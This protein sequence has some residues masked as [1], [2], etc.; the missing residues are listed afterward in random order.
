MTNKITPRHRVQLINQSTGWKSD[1]DYIVLV[2]LD[3]WLERQ[4]PKYPNATEIKIGD[5]WVKK[6][7]WKKYKR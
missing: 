3:N 1:A 7:D 2:E 5:D 4:L 6:I